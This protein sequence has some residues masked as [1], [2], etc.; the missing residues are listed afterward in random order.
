M[1]VCAAQASPSLNVGATLAGGFHTQGVSEPV[2]AWVVFRR[3]LSISNSPFY[4]DWCYSFAPSGL[5][6]FYYP[7]LPAIGISVN[8]PLFLRRSI[9]SEVT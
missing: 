5:T 8:G 1:W 4:A 7:T 6:K 9:S 2:I 3:R